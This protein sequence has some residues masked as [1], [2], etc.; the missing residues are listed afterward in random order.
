MDLQ[1]RF[2]QWVGRKAQ[3]KESTTQGSAVPEEIVSATF[4]EATMRI[5]DAILEEMISES[6]THVQF[7]EENGPEVCT[8]ELHLPCAG[9]CV[10]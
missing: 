5:A 7:P 4:V 9:P 8:T 10:L 1:A 2:R 6:A 3:T